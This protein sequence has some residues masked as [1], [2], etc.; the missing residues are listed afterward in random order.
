MNVPK[1]L[2]TIVSLL[3]VSA[4][5][6]SIIIAIRLLLKSNNDKLITGPSLVFFG[7]AVMFVFTANMIYKWKK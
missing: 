3:M 5:A 2:L 7:C 4:Y 1:K 6:L